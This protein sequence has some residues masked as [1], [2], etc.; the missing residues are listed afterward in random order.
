MKI[1]Y[2]KSNTAF[3]FSAQNATQKNVDTLPN[4]S[5]ANSGLVHLHIMKE[6][7]MGMLKHQEIV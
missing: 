4:T 3:K 6:Y 7:S 2:I 1:N 5:I